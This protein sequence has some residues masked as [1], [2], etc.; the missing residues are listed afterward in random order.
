MSLLDENIEGL[1]EIE[2]YYKFKKIKSGKKLLIIEDEKAK[3]LIKDGDKE[4]EKILTK[5][6]IL[7]WEEQN[8]VSSK[9][10]RFIQTIDPKTGQN[11]ERRQF[12]YVLYRDNIVKICLREWDL[13][14]NEKPVPV[15]PDL[16]NKLPGPVIMELFNKFEN[17]IDY[18]EEEIKN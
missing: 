17:V 16:I 11:I 9:S 15:T 7:N 14:I 5:W 1:V 12:D 18:T 10:V 4:I 8:K 6:K 13:T 2:L 3:K